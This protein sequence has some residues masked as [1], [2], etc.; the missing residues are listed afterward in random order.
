M[1]AILCIAWRRPS[2][3][4]HVLLHPVR[5]F[6]ATIAVLLPPTAG[7]ERNDWRLPGLSGVD[8]TVETHTMLAHPMHLRQHSRTTSMTNAIDRM[9]NLHQTAL[10]VRGYRGQV[11]ASN[12]ANADTP[13]YQARDVDFKAA[14][15]RASG[16]QTLRSIA[17]FH[18]R[19]DQGPAVGH[20]GLGDY[21][22]I[23]SSR[24]PGLR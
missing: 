21:S 1:Q 5:G 14:L 16:A 22:W 20:P 18:Q 4:L 2:V 3:E 10:S 8:R 23:R 9:F 15:T 7:R 19:Q 24:S 11:L 6:A 17:H 13:G 12:I